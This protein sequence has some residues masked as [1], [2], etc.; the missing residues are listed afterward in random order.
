MDGR[1]TGGW[2][3]DNHLGPGADRHCGR[4]DFGNFA[5]FRRGEESLAAGGATITS[6]LGPIDFAVGVIP[7]RIPSAVARR[8]SGA[9]IRILPKNRPA[10]EDSPSLSVNDTTGPVNAPDNACAGISHGW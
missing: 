8:G 7:S 4:L 5:I 1:E 3:G 9:A 6:A 10:V 2:R